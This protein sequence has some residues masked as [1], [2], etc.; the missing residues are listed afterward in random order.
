MK[1]LLPLFLLFATSTYADDSSGI[2]TSESPDQ[3]FFAATREVPSGD[4][5]LLWKT[6]F[7]GTRLVVVK[8]G[9]DTLGGDVY[10][11]F[12]FAGRLIEQ[13]KWTPDSKYIVFTTSSS[14]GH[15][16]WHDDSFVFSVT[17]KELVSVDDSVGL[18]VSPDVSVQAPHTATFEIGMVG[19]D[20]VDF[21][22]PKKT[23][24]DLSTLFSKKK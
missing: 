16:P 13:A 7:D 2:W 10:F 20:G 9:A 15:S 11:T 21:E 12:T 3:C 5:M 14:G 8:R 24:V 17:E 4:D 18:V 19:K 1:L 23:A 22:H 6:E